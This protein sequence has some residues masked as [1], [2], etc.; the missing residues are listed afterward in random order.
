[1]VDD[2]SPTSVHPVALHS[3]VATAD[4]MEGLQSISM[5]ASNIS[6]HAIAEGHSEHEETGPIPREN[7]AE[8]QQIS[9]PHHCD[10]KTALELT[11]ETTGKCIVIEAGEH[12]ISETIEIRARD[13]TI[14]AAYTGSSSEKRPLLRGK[15]VLCKG[16][17][18]SVEGLDLTSN[19]KLD[20][21]LLNLVCLFQLPLDNAWMSP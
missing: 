9:V 8:L 17:S 13:L 20:G 4:N 10:L 1:M 2:A 11:H 6:V 7:L 14:R 18:G 12:V 3:F 16:S 15:F 5:F 21:V 19:L